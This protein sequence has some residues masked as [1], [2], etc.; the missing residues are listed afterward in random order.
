M[1]G[2]EVQVQVSFAA[3]LGG[4]N[5]WIGNVQAAN[6]MLS[7]HELSCVH[8]AASGP[9]SS[10]SWLIKLT[11]GALA[12]IAEGSTAGAAGTW[13]GTATALAVAAAPLPPNSESGSAEVL[14]T[15]VRPGA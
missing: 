8:C 2:G 7:Q 14:G 5:V 1:V 6:R 9:A 11:A 10:S 15:Y 13:V 3:C 4:K 12:G